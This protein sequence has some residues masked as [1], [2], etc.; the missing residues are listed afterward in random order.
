MCDGMLASLDE[1]EE[2]IA[3]IRG[4]LADQNASSACPLDQWK[5]YDRLNLYGRGDVGR[6]RISDFSDLD[7]IKAHVLGQ[8]HNV[9]VLDGEWAYIKSFNYAPQRQEMDGCNGCQTLVYDP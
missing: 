4:M 2:Q 7:A 5:V 6:I 9:F 3:R 8:G 1:L